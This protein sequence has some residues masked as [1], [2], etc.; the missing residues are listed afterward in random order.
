[1][2]R[3]TDKWHA[4]V[5][6]V[7]S[8]S[9]QPHGPARP[10]C[11]WDFLGKNTGVSCHLLLQGFFLTQGSNLHLLHW[12]ADS[13][14]L[15]HLGPQIN[16]SFWQSEEQVMSWLE[17]YKLYGWVLG[18]YKGFKYRSCRTGLVWKSTQRMVW[19]V[20]RWEKKAKAKW[21]RTSWSG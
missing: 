20:Q 11:P 19:L 15:S 9:L 8:D 16:G 14:P 4:C 2:W 21:C 6:S 18:K 13:L 17:K 7:F 1:M 12:Q 5:C 3:D 10:L